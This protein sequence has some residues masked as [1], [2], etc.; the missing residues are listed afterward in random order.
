M[1]TAMAKITTIQE[2]NSKYYQLEENEHEHVNSKLTAS[3]SRAG[4]TVLTITSVLLISLVTAAACASLYHVWHSGDNLPE[5]SIQMEYIVMRNVI[6][7]SDTVCKDVTPKVI[8]CYYNFPS[9]QDFNQL[10]P[11]HIHPNLCTH[12][13]MAFA[14]VVNNEIQLDE[15]QYR[16]LL[17]IVKLKQHNPTL[18]ILVSV[19]GAKNDN[20]FPNMVLNHKSR[21]T[22]IKSIKN[23]LRNYS[24]DGIDLDWEFPALHNFA[25]AGRERQHFSQLLREIRMEYTRE[26]RNYLL[27]IAAAA[28]KTIVDI[29]YDVDQLNEYLDFVNIMTYDYHYFTKYTP[30]TGFNSPLYQRS[31]EQMYLATLNINYTVHMYLDKGLDRNKIVVGIPT[32]GHTFTLFNPNN[33][34]VNS[35]ASGF[36]ALGSLGFVNY[37]DV[38][39]F[40]NNTSNV[41]IT[42]DDD[43]KVPYLYSH[44][45]WVSYEGTQSVE[46]KAKFIVENKLGGAMIYSLNADDYAGMCRGALPGRAGGFPLSATSSVSGEVFIIRVRKARDTSAL[47]AARWRGRRPRGRRGPQ[48]GAAAAALR[49]RAAACSS[50]Q[51]R[52]RRIH[53]TSN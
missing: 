6:Q 11:Y 18:K 2:S 23:L 29:S 3:S 51:N 32:Y 33:H 25:T 50:I 27:T 16:T 19:G 14:R 20:G 39:A 36:G 49:A 28:P 22:F 38:C 24:L 9:E 53:Y 12:I 40:V 21:K 1:G 4:E 37:P 13:N 17:E 8:S 47:R 45:E 31:T 44:K 10:M 7:E 48:L 46:E 41:K 52:T 5:N 43:A 35:P 30:F 34:N 15:Y 26:K 42:E